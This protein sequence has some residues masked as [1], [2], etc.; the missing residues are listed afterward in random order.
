MDIV[1]GEGGEV[2]ENPLRNISEDRGD[3]VDVLDDSV[4]VDKLDVIGRPG[5]ADGNEPYAP[6]PGR[7][8]C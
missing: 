5:E 8:K 4:V 2:V 7:S 1:G 6:L 3:V